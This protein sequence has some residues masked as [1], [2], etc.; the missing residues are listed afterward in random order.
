VRA[1]LERGWKVVVVVA[2]DFHCVGFPDLEVRRGRP[3]ELAQWLATAGTQPDMVRVGPCGQ[4]VR[5]LDGL[6]DLPE[7]VVVGGDM[8]GDELAA[9]GRLGYRREF[10]MLPGEWPAGGP[11]PRVLDFGPLKPEIPVRGGEK[12]YLHRGGPA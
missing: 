8:A 4:A 5:W 9:L 6:A 11:L 3:P 12:V 1:L 2:E 10:R 7:Y